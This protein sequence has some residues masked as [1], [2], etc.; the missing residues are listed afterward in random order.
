MTGEERVEVGRVVK[1]H[2][3]RGEVLVRLASDVPGRLAPGTRVW[4]A[5]VASEV[6]TSREHQGRPL[7][8][9]TH[10]ADRTGAELLRGA[11]VEAAPVDAAELDTYL[12]SEL[13]GVR[14]LDGEGALLG[15]V[16][17]LVAMPAV[18]GY[19]L[20]EVAA[21]DGGTWLLPA[22]DALV[23]AVE[24]ADGLHLVAHDLPEG[25]IGTAMDAASDVAP[26][27]AAGSGEGRA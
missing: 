26:D 25:L 9:F 21:P 10:V 20:L 19:D 5:G 1:A 12:A 7:V 27:A 16:R 3:L 17:S 23:E 8:R 11:V 4:V 6:A 15:I 13:V 18:A 24:D 2:G 14:V 22:A